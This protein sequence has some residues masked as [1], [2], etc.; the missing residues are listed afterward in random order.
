MLPGTLKVRL[1]S[2]FAHVMRADSALGAGTKR[3]S[4]SSQGQRRRATRRL[5]AAVKDVASGGV[6]DRRKHLTKDNVATRHQ[7]A[8]FCFRTFFDRI[9]VFSMDHCLY[10][11]HFV[12]GRFVFLSL[13]LFSLAVSDCIR[14]MQ[15]V[16]FFFP[17]L[18]LSTQSPNSFLFCIFL[19]LLRTLLSR[20]VDQRTLPRTCDS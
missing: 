2:P 7:F 11:A 12:D 16:S 19:L 4:R 20:L 17:P 13:L 18:T 5:L 6:A 9:A 1:E 3:V 14:S 10:S 15:R 8:F